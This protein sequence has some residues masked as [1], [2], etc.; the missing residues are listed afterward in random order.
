MAKHVPV[1]LQLEMMECGA[2][3][4]TMILA[5]YDK[6]IPL[7]QI[8]NDCGVSR[9]GLKA[10][11]ILLTARKYGMQ[12]DGYRF[13]VKGLK[14]R[15]TFPCILHWG[16]CHFVVCNG[17]KGD[18][19]FLNDPAKGAVTVTLDE[20]NK[21]FTGVC[22][23]LEPGVNFEASG[24]KKS[25]FGFV[26]RRMEGNLSATAFVMFTTLIVMA[27]SILLATLSKFF[28]DYLITGKNMKLAN[29]FFLVMLSVSFMQIIA[30]V[31]QGVANY[32]IQGKMGIIGNYEFF[33]SVMHKPMHF[34]SQR[35]A[36]DIMARQ[37]VNGMIA[38]TLINVLAPLLMSGSMLLFYLLVML[39]YS[40]PMTVIGLVSLFGNILVSRYISKKRLGI[41]KV[42]LRDSGKLSSVTVSGI[43]MIET[44]KATGSES[45]YFEKWSGYQ[46]SVNR[47]RVKFANVNAYLGSIPLLLT[48]LADVLVLLAGAYF[49]MRGEFTVGMIL[50][51]QTFLQQF[52]QPANQIINAGQTIQ[53]MYVNM[54]R[55]DDILD[56]PEDT[57]F[58]EGARNQTEKLTGAVSIRNVI[59]GYSRVD[60]PLIEDFQM[61]LKPGKSV[62]FVGSSGCGK[63][64]ISKLISGLY[65]PWSGEILFDGK[66]IKEIDRDVFTSSV[67]VVDQDIVLF[68]DTIANNIRM[69]DNSIEDFEVIMA[70][71]DAQM[72]E[73]IMAREGG[74][75]YKILENGKDFSGGQRQ[76]LEIARVLAQ[77]PTLIIMD[78]ATSALDAKTEHD[79]VKKIKDRG[80]ACI[81]VAHR[82]STVRDCD[83]I[84]VLQN[85]KIVERGTHEEL[86]DKGGVYTELVINE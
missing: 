4:L 60:K 57:I 48:K 39:K 27:T 71:R 69:W 25:I 65:E 22:I 9:D 84:I 35:M 82:L 78:E 19:V 11:N 76:R 20:F 17:F 51:F 26:K 68:E 63:S 59:F 56:Y 54:E 47:S 74:Y 52:M 73:E 6:W 62:A 67:V 1:I 16:F 43:D 12:A 53:E 86:M 32:K 10:K 58:N 85:G 21:L 5:Y 66:S 79:V 33:W 7:E 75:Q 30:N 72:H 49:V 14:E 42:M 83:E 50:A 38:N 40:V 15:G 37:N 18:K 61:E 80:I 41:S 64:T 81:V 8:R 36:G 24:K 70:A 23:V 55:V 34:F 29:P 31:L 28:L 45:G 44:I 3:C 13:S 77:D 46:A 2:A